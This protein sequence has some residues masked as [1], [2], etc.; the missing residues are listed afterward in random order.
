MLPNRLRIRSFV[1]LP[2]IV[3]LCATALF[4][5]STPKALPMTQA[6]GTFDVKV[7]PVE[8]AAAPGTATYSINKTF[9]GDL[10]ATSEGEMFSAGDYK[11]G[12]AGYVALERVTGTLGGRSGSFALMHTGIMRSGEAPAMTVTIVPGSGTGE[13]TGITGTLTIIITD[14]KHSY[15]LN[16]SLPTQ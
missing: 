14:G 11:Q 2:L 10:E 1:H 15:T 12:N 7:L 9:H 5:Q 3:L 8:H 6:T 16:Y 13:L 4:A